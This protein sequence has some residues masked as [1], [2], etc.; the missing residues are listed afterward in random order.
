[1]LPVVKGKDHTR[2][3][4][5]LYTLLLVPLGV[6]PVAIGIGGPLYLAVSAGIGLW[7]LWEA[8]CVF[9]ERDAVKEPAAHRLFGVS[10]LYLAALFAALIVE[11]LVG[12]DASFLSAV[13]LSAVFGA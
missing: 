2:L 3:Q 13:P 7:F 12:L 1:M 5:L 10:L 11:K 9:R 6:A 8:V 4:I